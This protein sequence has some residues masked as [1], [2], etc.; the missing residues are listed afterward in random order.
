ML[1]QTNCDALMIGRGSIINPFIFHQIK[2]QFSRT[3][4][5]AKWED[6]ERYFRIYM[7]SL[8]EGTR[9]KMRL[10]KLKQLFGFLFK[11]S[12]QLMMHRQSVLKSQFDDPNELLQFAL[13]LL[14][15]LAFN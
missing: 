6:L 1:K 11:G 9:N 7:E 3:S 12:E 14:K 5:E 8:S 10:N 15:T 13:P 4:F 2:A